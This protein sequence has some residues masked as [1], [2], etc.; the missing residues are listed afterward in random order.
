MI[1]LRVPA[2][3]A[4]LGPGFDALGLAL[5]LTAH[6]GIA[7]G[8]VPDGAR[9]VDERHPADIAFRRGGGEGA[10][11]VRSPIPMA[12]GLGYSGAMRVGGLAAAAV[13]RAGGP[14]D[15]GVVAPVLLEHAVELEGHADNVAASLHGGFVATAAGRV[16]RVPLALEPAVVLWI[17]SQ[18]TSTQRSRHAL[19]SSVSFA[20]A[21]F[22]VGRTA[23][24][25]AALASGDVEALRWATADRLH[26]DR[27][28]AAAP[29]SR[30]ALSLGLDA[31]AWCG[32]LSG[33]GPSVAFLCDPDAA[34]ALAA[35]LPPDGHTKVVAVAAR[36]VELLESSAT[37]SPKNRMPS[38]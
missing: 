18:E 30:D 15:L 23:L 12:R 29:T 26:Q 17:P 37:E 22:N 31:G 11:W 20:D 4:N 34:E 10:L 36:G 1:A 24:L 33:S 27:R 6:V 14:I 21:T 25:V 32:W 8:A 2:S 3:T 5:E 9:L 38:F 7:E 13:Q 16:A 35:A 28:L 19:P